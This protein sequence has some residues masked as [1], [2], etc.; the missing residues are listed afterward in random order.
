MVLFGQWVGIVSAEGVGQMAERATR[1]AVPGQQPRASEADPTPRPAV[2]PPAS[3]RPSSPTGSAASSPTDSVPVRQDP[4]RETEPAR[5]EHVHSEPAAPQPPQRH[6]VRQQVLAALREALLSGE[7]A[8]G[9]V[10][11]AP[12]LAARFGVSATPVREAMQRLASE[13]AVETVPNRGF[14]VAE[15]TPGDLAE[16]AEVRALLEIPT[17]LALARTRPPEVWRALRPL[18]EAAYDCATRGDLTG[19]VVADQTF[20]RA[21]VEVGGN[22]QLAVL[23]AELCRQ[24]QC[25]GASREGLA[26]G[27]ALHGALLDALSASDLTRAEALLREQLAG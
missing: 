17:V 27:G 19:Y 25:G 3:P 1:A 26:A 23:V 4:P 11:S 16:L 20:H 13:G 12:V 7:L 10:Y 14:R 24:S 9:Q 5:G 8:P 22:R 2:P 18:A 15:R 21:L 6:S